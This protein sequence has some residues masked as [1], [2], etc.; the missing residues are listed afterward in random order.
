MTELCDICH[1]PHPQLLGAA[2]CIQAQ[3]A[4][5]LRLLSLAGDSGHCEGCGSQVF[6]VRHRNGRITPYTPQGLNHFINCPQA[7]RFKR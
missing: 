7:A 1:L 4:A 2:S 3:E 6:W 5:M